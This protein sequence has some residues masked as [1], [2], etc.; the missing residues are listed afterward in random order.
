MELKVTVPAATKAIVGVPAS[1][2]KSVKLNGKIV[3]E[4]GKFLVKTIDLKDD[5]IQGRIVFEVSSGDWQFLT[6]KRFN[7]DR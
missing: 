3:W 7:M 1:G 2:V 5:S 4:N 6:E